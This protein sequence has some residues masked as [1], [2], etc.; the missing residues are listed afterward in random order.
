MGL[1]SPALHGTTHF[2]QRAVAHALTSDGA[3]GK[4]LRALWKAETPYIHWRMPW[5]GYEYWD[6]ERAPVDRFIP[7]VDQERWI[8]WAAQAYRQFFEDNPVSACAPGYRA[9]STTH[10]LWKGHGIRVAQNGSGTMR[11]P[12]FDERGLFHTYRSLDFEPALSPELDWED[13]VRKAAT[14]LDRGMP[15][16]VST[17]SINFHSTLAPYRQKTLPMLRDFL[18]G[19]AKRYPDLVY[20]NTRQLLEMVETGSYE[21]GSGRV[22]VAVTGMR[23]GVAS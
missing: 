22:A 9:D 7:E 17:H 16:I 1:L 2:C 20:V 13:C 15:L 12:H 5:V 19:L 11:A 8:G 14:W 23:K 18:S 6:P 21:T 10:R 4:L 3:R